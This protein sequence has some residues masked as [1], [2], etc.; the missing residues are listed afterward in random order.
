MSCQ[1]KL[2]DPNIQSNQLSDRDRILVGLN[3]GALRV[4]RLNELPP[5]E[6]NGSANTNPPDSDD[7]ASLTPQPP[8]PPPKPTDLLREVEKFSTRAIEQLAI[9]KEATTL[10][11]L[12]NYYISLHNL[13][14]YEL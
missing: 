7:D 1:E 4:Y 12:S 9:V 3:S 13:Q 6:P 8:Q 2:S 10:V 5:S 11:S 14:T